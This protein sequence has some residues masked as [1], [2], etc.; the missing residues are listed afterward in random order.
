M[1]CSGQALGAATHH[2]YTTNN[3]FACYKKHPLGTPPAR[4]ASLQSFFPNLCQQSK[5]GKVRQLQQ[6]HSAECGSPSRVVAEQRGQEGR[7][8]RPG[9]EKGCSDK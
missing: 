4:A 7:A 1:A 2:C 6:A 9:A 8:G 3:I 5:R